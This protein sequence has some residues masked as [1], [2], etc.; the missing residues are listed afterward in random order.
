MSGGVW[1]HGDGCSENGENG[2]H[3][4]FRW[5]SPGRPFWRVILEGELNEARGDGMITCGK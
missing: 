3:L 2:K 1:G 5:Y 4:L